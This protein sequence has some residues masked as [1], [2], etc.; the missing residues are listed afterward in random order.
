[1]KIGI[2]IGSVRDGRIGAGVAQWVHEQAQGREATYELIDLKE[3]DLPVLTTHQIPSTAGKD[4]WDERV[5][6]W[7]AAVDAC[8]GYVFVTPE[9]NH[10]LPGGLKNA[11]DLLFP[12]WWSKA[13]AFVSYGAA[14]GFRVVEQW[15]PVVANANM[16]DIKA[17]VALSTMIDFTDGV[18]QPAERHP[19]ELAAMFDS[20][21]KA[22]AALT[23]MRG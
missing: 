12:E 13:V 23:T 9:Y 8:Q 20:L 18:L 21:E 22:T 15:R 2:I 11:F 5:N 19:T 3:F 7:S 14:S 16:F 6:R 4:Y 10:G 17:Q 1:M